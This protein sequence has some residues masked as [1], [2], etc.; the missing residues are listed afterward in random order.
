MNGMG[1]SH[2]KAEES[3]DL[4]IPWHPLPSSMFVNQLSPIYT[5]I[6]KQCN[7]NCHIDKLCSLFYP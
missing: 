1:S 2:V 6:M 3:S 5:N 4:I 7:V